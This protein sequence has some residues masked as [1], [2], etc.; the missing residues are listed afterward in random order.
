MELTQKTIIINLKHYE[1]SSGQRC[2]EFLEKFRG[3]NFPED[4]RVIF[5]LNPI[6]LRLTEKFQELL[7]YS[8]HV[9]DV[10]RGAHTGKFSID[11]VREL[12][13]M[14]TILN[15]SERR[16]DLRTIEKTLE[17]AKKR[18]FPIVVCCET[19]EEAS[20]IAPLHPEAI[21]YEPAELIG[22]NISVTTAKPEIITETVSICSRHGVPVLVGAG[23]KSHGDLSGSLKLG[24]RGVLLASGIVLAKDP[25]A[26]LT[27][28]IVNQ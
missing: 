20:R 15:H 28:L 16:L 13:I 23:V 17:M 27:S 11:A 12:G 14:G 7:F 25:V 10:E 18:M 9:D 19:T 6:D 3:F 5:A 2:S 21:A 26:S 22:G 24:A 1:S 8:Q 4:Y